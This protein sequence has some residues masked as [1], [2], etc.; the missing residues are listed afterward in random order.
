M[1]PMA[2][3]VYVRQPYEQT[4][5]HGMNI[6]PSQQKQQGNVGLHQEM[7]YDRASMEAA[8]LSAFEK[9]RMQVSTHTQRACS[10]MQWRSVL[11]RI[12]SFVDVLTQVSSL[13]FP[14]RCCSG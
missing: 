8:E 1:A 6:A 14:L 3:E 10:L 7:A 5:T 4:N 11:A 13:L 9:G 12:C 2:E